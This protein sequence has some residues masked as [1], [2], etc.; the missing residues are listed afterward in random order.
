MKKIQEKYHN[1]M[2]NIK[3]SEGETNSIKQNILNQSNKHYVFK[4]AF[5]SLI[6]LTIIFTL[7]ITVNALVKHYNIKTNE[8]Y[9]K[10]VVFNGVIDKK[11]DSG[12]FEKNKRYTIEELEEKL[13]LKILR[14]K[15]I[16]NDLFELY[17]LSNKENQ[18]TKMNFWLINKENSTN[19]NDKINYSFEINTDL[20]EGSR[21]A[22]SGDSQLEIY[23]IKTLDTEAVIIESKNETYGPLL[24][25]FEYDGIIYSIELDKIDFSKKELYNILNSFFIEK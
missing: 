8:E 4:P 14:N 19:K 11:Y 3:L 6:I 25:N 21:F 9:K 24:A 2:E 23:K 13:E 18:I 1:L 10:D 15:K 22:M 12:L 17:N 5:A 7:G 20:K 16:D